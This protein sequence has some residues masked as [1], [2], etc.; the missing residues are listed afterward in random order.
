MATRRG[1]FLRGADWI[2]AVGAGTTLWHFLGSQAAAV[3]IWAP[4]VT[5]LVLLSDW[6]RPVPFPFLVPAA[7][8][9]YGGIV[10]SF[11]VSARA[12]DRFRER[13]QKITASYDRSV[14]SCRAD[15][16]FGDG[17]HS[18]CFRLRVENATTRKLHKCEGWLE[19]TDRFPNISATQLFWVGNP[20]TE[21][22]IDLI[23]GIPRFLQICRISSDNRIHMATPREQWPID[24]LRFPLGDYVFKIGI[25]GEDNAETHFYAAKL[26]WT[27]NWTT[28]EMV[29]VTV[30]DD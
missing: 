4:L 8:L 29:P 13:Y 9:A 26:I 19:S 3:Y 28:A 2:R 20:D 30:A 23:K 7:V 25:K 12:L 5:A 16:T 1:W 21:L 11:T 17:S 6:L 18:I 15:V 14:P 27:G 24:S 22:S 10:W